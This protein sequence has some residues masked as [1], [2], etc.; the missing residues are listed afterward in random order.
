MTKAKNHKITD[1][2]AVRG[3]KT[4]YEAAHAIRALACM[5]AVSLTCYNSEQRLGLIE[6][7]ERNAQQ[8]ERDYQAS[9]DADLSEPPWRLWLKQWGYQ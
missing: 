1:L 6:E 9:E 4:R 2:T 3:S 8:L 5:Q 7:A